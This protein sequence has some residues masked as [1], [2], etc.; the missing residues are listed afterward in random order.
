MFH[1]QTIDILS[2][3]YIIVVTCFVWL[4][5]SIKQGQASHTEKSSLPIRCK[6]AQSQ[7]IP[8][9]LYHRKEC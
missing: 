1:Q 3:S 5:T 7:R 2:I 9:S 4:Y 8:H 6:G